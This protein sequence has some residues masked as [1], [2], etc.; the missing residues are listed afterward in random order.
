MNYTLEI[1]Q[2]GSVR[3]L[4]VSFASEAPFGAIGTG[5]IINPGTWEGSQSPM[6]VLRVVAVEH[7]VWGHQGDPRHKVMVFSEEVEGTEE[8]R[9]GE[10]P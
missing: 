8:L 10:I 7:L 5:D 4:W 3:D 6:R 2:P 1:Y 9:R